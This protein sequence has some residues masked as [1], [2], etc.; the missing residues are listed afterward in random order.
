M[1]R[2]ENKVFDWE[3][4]EGK[5]KCLT[6]KIYGGENKVFDWKIMPAKELTKSQQH[7]VN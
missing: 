5:T 1:G 3:N 6:G 7:L 4:T 2:G